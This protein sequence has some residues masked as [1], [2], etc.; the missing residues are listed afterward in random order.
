MQIER[1]AAEENL[2]HNQTESYV[3]YVHRIIANESVRLQ[4]V[5]CFVNIKET[6]KK[7]ETENVYSFLK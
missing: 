4:N 2:L 5:L 7:C 3:D 6:R 1:E